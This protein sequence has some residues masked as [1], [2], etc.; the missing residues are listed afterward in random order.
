MGSAPVEGLPA[1]A[2][3]GPAG[4]VVVDAVALPGSGIVIAQAVA[5]GP[6]GR[7]LGRRAAGA[8]TR[9]QQ[10]AGG[11]F[12]SWSDRTLSQPTRASGAIGF[13]SYDDAKK[14]P[15]GADARPFLVT[16]VEPEIPQNTGNI[17]RLCAATQC[18]LHLV[19]RLG[20]RIDERSVRRAGIDYWHL[21]D[22]HVHP[23]WSSFSL[24]HA[25][26][27]AR[28]KI[29]SANADELPRRGLCAGRRAGVRQGEHRRP[30]R[31][32][33]SLPRWRVRNP[34]GRR[35]ALDQPGERRGHRGV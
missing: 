17:A 35:G 32:A 33:R 24:V 5:R 14:A 25:P 34:H 6:S 28:V 23:D 27:P 3:E 30:A 22:L 19:G 8:R 7:R 31:G 13:G 11:G 2:A 4:G 29:F 26:D 18:P 9:P 10:P 21:V 20:F 15:R 16:L 12:S 1:A